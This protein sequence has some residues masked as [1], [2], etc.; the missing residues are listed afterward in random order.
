[1]I[2][3]NPF[4]AIQ[5]IAEKRISEAIESGEFENLPGKGKPLE[6]KD[7]SHVPPELRMAYKILENS[8]CLPPE[9]ADRKEI[10]SLV[11]LLDSCPD[12]REKLKHMRRLRVLLERRVAPGKNMLLEQHDDYYQKILARLEKHERQCK[13]RK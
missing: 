13:S 3:D 2:M 8:G 11:D 6:F 5:F 9:I 12:E 1:M 4:S 10:S 7:M